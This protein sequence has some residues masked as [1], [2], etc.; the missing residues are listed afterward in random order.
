MSNSMDSDKSVVISTSKIWQIPSR[1]TTVHIDKS[2]DT[3][4]FDKDLPFNC[5]VKMFGVLQ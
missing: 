4:Q 3:D 5:S 1:L 2:M